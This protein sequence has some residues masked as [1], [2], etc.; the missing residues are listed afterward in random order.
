VPRTPGHCGEE[1]KSQ[2]PTVPV[3]GSPLFNTWEGCAGV[4]RGRGCLCEAGWC[5]RTSGLAGG[6]CTRGSL[7]ARVCT[8]VRPPRVASPLACVCLLL[9]AWQREPLPAPICARASAPPA[10]RGR[11]ACAARSLKRTHCPL[12]SSATQS[13]RL[14][15]PLEPQ[16]SL[17]ASPFLL[18]S[19]S[20]PWPGAWGS[21]SP[22][23][24]PP[25]PR[26]H[27]AAPQGP[28]GSSRGLCIRASSSSWD[29]RLLDPFHR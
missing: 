6:G 16:G 5:P 9:Q 25:R 2:L 10:Q 23:I 19:P 7:G 15:G 27:H 28:L 4:W 14:P 24:C 13:P 17:Q 8:C 3:S 11:P 1:D 21:E 18:P 22:H 29:S 26:Q 12:A 20:R